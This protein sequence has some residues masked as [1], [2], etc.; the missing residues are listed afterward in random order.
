MSVGSTPFRQKN[1][2]PTDVWSSPFNLLDNFIAVL[3][4]YCVHQMP[5]GKLPLGKMPLG[6][7]VFNQKLW[8]HINVSIG[9]GVAHGIFVF[10]MDSVKFGATTLSIKTLSI[11]TLDEEWCTA[12]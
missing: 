5:L 6:K 4:D 3:S 7:M 1:I 9:V 11:T 12:Q 8:N 10:L 2:W